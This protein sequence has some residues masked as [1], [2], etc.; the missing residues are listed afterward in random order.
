[1]EV[2]LFHTDMWTDKMKL[3]F[4]LHYC[5]VNAPK[6]A[7]NGFCLI[8]PC[9]PCGFLHRN[10]ECSCDICS[11]FYR[12]CVE[13]P[14]ARN[15]TVSFSGTYS[16]CF[17][18]ITPCLVIHKDLTRSIGNGS[19]VFHTHKCGCVLVPLSGSVS[20]STIVITVSEVSLLCALLT[21]TYHTAQLNVSQHS[22]GFI[23][24]RDPS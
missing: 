4:D 3:M 9:H 23:P 13:Q 7:Y 17:K 24:K 16:F 18:N 1:M 10:A 15:C 12:Q 19:N 2:K 22:L 14:P 6:N 8:L 5:F 21:V 20:V 11:K